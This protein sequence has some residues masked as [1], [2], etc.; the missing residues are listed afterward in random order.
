MREREKE[1]ER[2]RISM[3]AFVVRDRSGGRY[4]S[5]EGNRKVSGR[6]KTYEELRKE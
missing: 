3:C 1:R 5:G 4:V 6:G 2:K